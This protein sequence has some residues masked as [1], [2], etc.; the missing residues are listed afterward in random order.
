MSRKVSS[1]NAGSK[2]LAGLI[3]GAVVLG[4]VAGC[5]SAA[6]SGTSAATS[7]STATSTGAGDETASASGLFD[8]TTVQSISVDVDPD[9]Y[10]TM[11][12]SYVDTGEKEWISATVTINGTV[13]SNVGIKLKGNSSL[14]GLRGQGPGGAAVGRPTADG[15]ESTVDSSES[16]VDAE[17]TTAPSTSES[18]AASTADAEPQTTDAAAPGAGGFMGGAS[19]SADEPEG[20]PW[21]IRLDKFVEGQ[22]YQGETDFVV[23]AN[24]SETSLNEAVALELIDAAGMP[25][26]DAAPVKF[27]VNGSEQR[28]RLLVETPDDQWYSDN[29]GAQGILYKA[30]A[31]GDY[32]YRGDDPAAYTEVFEVEANTS[33]QSGN[34]YAPLISFL[35]WLGESDDATFAAEL[36]Q[37]LDID[38]FADYLA[39][40]DLVANSDDIDGPGNN[41]YLSY[42]EATGLFTVISWDQNLAF[43]GMGEM[44]G[45]GRPDGIPP[46]GADGQNF[47]PPSGFQ[48]PEGMELPSGVDLPE[49]MQMPG[50][51]N[52]G[53]GRPGGLGGNVLSEKFLANEQFAA[54]VTQATTD[55]RTELYSSGTAQQILDSW[56]TTLTEQASDLVSADTITSESSAIA[57]HFT[58]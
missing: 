45:G 13:F 18:A 50:G 20:L 39:I 42:D 49:G 27:T 11:I 36:D 22:N 38:S 3:T 44:G 6:D 12:D 33:E 52:A 54:L 43:G 16:T 15:S 24:N 40:Q 56:T 53:G 1:S 29:V 46:T 4:S 30:E 25:S 5:T 37:W 35:K 32:S 58:S 14:M 26:E 48:L 7:G 55:L 47:T 41:S 19:L 8:S 51:G 17:A 28:L 57:G 31:G 10:Q 34:E 9:T 21:R 23:R 2:L